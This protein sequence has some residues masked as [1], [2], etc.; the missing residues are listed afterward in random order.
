MRNLKRV[1]SLALAAIMLMGMMVMGTG[2]ANVSDFTDSDKITNLEAASVTTAIDIFSGYG[3]GSFGG[4]R[5]V[6]R[7]EMA[8]IICKILV[9]SNVNADIYK[10]LGN[11]QD[12]TDYEWA[13]G[14]INMCY[15]QGIVNGTST[16]TY[17]PGR[18]VKT[19]EAALM[20]QR[21]L[22]W[23]AKNDPAN[24]TISELT[25][26]NKSKGLGLYGDLTL[27]AEEYLTRNDVAEMVFNTITKCVP[28]A[29]NDAFGQ[30][31]NA[32][33]TN[34]FS[35]V[36][37]NYAD[38]LA[39]QTF[40]LV[41]AEG[42]T[43][44]FGRP[45]I[46][47]GYGKLDASSH[48]DSDGNIDSTQFDVDDLTK[49]LVTVA[50]TP[51]LEY[52][53]KVT[54]KMLYNELNLSGSST[55]LDLY[56][57]GK[58]DAAG[59][60]AIPKDGEPLKSDGGTEITGNGVLT[61]VY[62]TDGASRPYKVVV[63]NTY[64][65]KVDTV[66]EATRN[67]DAKVTVDNCDNDPGNYP[68]AAAF[69]ADY[70]T[71]AFAKD[72]VVLITMAYDDT[73]SEYQIQ[74]MELADSVRGE[75]TRYTATKNTM[76]VDG[77]TYSFNAKSNQ[78]A[79]DYQANG[80][81]VGH[82]VV[83]YLD[84]YGYA[85]DVQD[86]GNEKVTNYALVLAVDKDSA[87]VFQNNSAYVKLL[88]MDNTVVQAKFSWEK[89]N[90][91]HWSYDDLKAVGTKQTKETLFTNVQTLVTYSVDNKGTY[92]LYKETTDNWD[93]LKTDSN[94]ATVSDKG[95]NTKYM[96]NSTVLIRA[97]DKNRD[98]YEIYIG[99][100]N[101]PNI[102]E[103]GRTQVALDTNTAL[104]N[105]IYSETNV[106]STSK[107]L[108][109]I[110]EKGEYVNDK[111]LGPYVNYT[112]VVNGVITE[113]KVKGE[114]QVDGTV[115]PKASTNIKE[116]GL[117]SSITTRDGIVTGAKYA[118]P[119]EGNDYMTGYGMVRANKE[120]IGIKDV[121]DSGNTVYY[122]WSDDVLVAHIELDANGKIV[123]SNPSITS[124]RDSDD[125]YVYYG[126]ASGNAGQ[127]TWLYVVEN[128]V[129]EA[130][131]AGKSQTYD[132][133]GAE[134]DDVIQVT[135]GDNTSTVVVPAKGTEGADAATADLAKAVAKL[136][137]E[138][139]TLSLNDDDML[140]VQANNSDTE[141]TNVHVSVSAGNAATTN[142]AAAEAEKP[143][144]AAD[145]TVILKQ[146]GD[147][148]TCD[149]TTIAYNGA[150]DKS[151]T[152]CDG[153]NVSYTVTVSGSEVTVVFTAKTA[154]TDA[155][156]TQWTGTVDG[157]DT[158]TG[159]LNGGKDV[160]PATFGTRTYDLTGANSVGSIIII[161]GTKYDVTTTVKA[162]LTGLTS[163][164]CI[165]SVD[166]A[167]HLTAAKEAADKDY[168]E[169]TVTY[170]TPADLLG[171]EVDPVEEDAG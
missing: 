49:S 107:D 26:S 102:D 36:A 114:I 100:R 139:Y 62:K 129:G 110:A 71:E 61:Q 16:T 91:D 76:V 94:R 8:T 20:L 145:A 55:V 54:N 95:V 58:E 42:D 74:T 60:A 29:Y 53:T 171:D 34:I 120:I 158:A 23:W 148:V 47:W 137:L 160:V 157:D 66:T 41:Y 33:N 119:G 142:D 51:V 52:T 118:T 92:T 45:V 70:E 130:T 136:S 21:A 80:G 77:V 134:V 170:V 78:D 79:N 149:G 115:E 97:V 163:A 86:A 84:N 143:A 12:L 167:G 68:T 43:D 27:Y 31:R 48:I 105:A 121:N 19:W 126:V 50:D 87:D 35:G 122:T 59:T 90:A 141:I 24:A 96:N 25:V 15:G 101:I 40:G 22:G 67:E 85:I 144:E 57:D 109:Y 169:W 159:T 39:Y 28:V 3:D 135:D 156:G 117:Y 93:A 103:A 162:A 152:D 18:P 99:V 154:G 108:I 131:S 111:D 75:M 153:G 81:D 38:T 32:S 10:G 46:T 147:E 89:D 98:K 30:Y 73:A 132:I 14:Y 72:D 112:A 164:G 82:N 5:Y 146:G 125:C 6:N 1:L 83:V 13:E 116:G 128:N 127:I 138:G 166:D 113:L 123:V 104:V 4:D 155:N 37:F 165:I 11:F 2:A 88:L 168:P 9:G 133:S 150:S 124:L 7:A 140:V 56:V 106:S 161:N 65:M 17:E 69:N 44:A 151:D 64:I 63:I